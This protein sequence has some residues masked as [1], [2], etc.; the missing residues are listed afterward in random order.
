MYVKGNALSLSKQIIDT[1]ELEFVTF[2]FPKQIL[3]I[4]LYVIVV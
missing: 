3:S 2:E 4:Y 1:F